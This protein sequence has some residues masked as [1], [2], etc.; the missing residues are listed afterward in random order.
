MDVYGLGAVLYE[1]PVLSLAVSPDGKTLASGG[2][3]RTVRLW[4]VGSGRE[5]AR[6]VAHESAVT[7]RAFSPVGEVLT[8]GSAEGT[9]KSWHLPMLR[10]EL[11]AIGLDW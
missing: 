11:A 5:L 3:D 7:A 1:Y 9:L 10:K 8:S 2:E 4:D 6:W